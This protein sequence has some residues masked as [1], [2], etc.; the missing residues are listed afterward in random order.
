MFDDSW[1]DYGSRSWQSGATSFNVNST[2]TYYVYAQYYW[3]AD[4]YV[5]AGGDGG[6]LGVH[7]YNGRLGMGNTCR[8]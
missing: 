5:A 3:F 8:F 6:F 1:Y 4:R 2:G 7:D